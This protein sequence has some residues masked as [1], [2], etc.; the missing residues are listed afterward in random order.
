MCRTV[1]APVDHTIFIDHFGD[2]G[3]SQL[4]I[5]PTDTGKPLASQV[6]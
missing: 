6:C 5:Q 2:I 1:C 4:N 3:I